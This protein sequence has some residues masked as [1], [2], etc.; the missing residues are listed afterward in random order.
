MATSRTDFVVTYGRTTST[1]VQG[2]SDWFTAHLYPGESL[3]K[4]WLPG[5]SAARNSGPVY[6]MLFVRHQQREDRP[7]LTLPRMACGDSR[8]GRL[9]ASSLSVNDSPDS[10]APRGSLSS[11][12]AFRSKDGAAT[13]GW[14]RF[15][16]HG[17]VD[18]R[19]QRAE[20]HQRFHVQDHNPRLQARRWV[21]LRDSKCGAAPWRL[22]R[23]SRI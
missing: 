15:R 17:R 12:P 6:C 3:V 13:D 1:F 16:S 4:T 9:G 20:L 22:R 19:P 14:R 18:A 21:L 10:R 23:G 11:A 8:R 7:E 5:R 2:V